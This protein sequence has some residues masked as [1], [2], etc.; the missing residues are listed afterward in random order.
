M[1]KCDQ[2]SERCIAS[3]LPRQL[4][5]DLGKNIAQ[6]EFKK[7]DN[8]FREGA[9]SQS[10]AFLKCGIVKL[11][12]H[13]PVKEKILRIVK[14]P[15]YIGLP[16]SISD[17]INHFS[18]TAII[19]TTVCFIDLHQFR[20]FIYNNGK[21]AYDIMV[22][23]CENELLDYQRY[24][25]QSQKQLPGMIAETILCLS[26]RIF[27]SNRFNFPL[28]QSELGDL[29]GTS[30]ES[31]SRILSDFSQNKIIAF[32]GKELNILNRDVLEEISA[33]G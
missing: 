29:V 8:I 9:L 15:T 32:N 16:T 28:T 2:C 25:N 3:N 26:D 18:A 33:K 12:L 24:T 14:A 17:N 6:I 21:F 22:E 7:G 20:E 23:M 5:D 11:H 10:V 19:D 1:F 30:R 27:N 31:V 4:L 13:G